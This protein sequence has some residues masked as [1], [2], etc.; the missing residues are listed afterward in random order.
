MLLPF[1]AIS[2]KEQKNT[3][4]L[5]KE[6]KEADSYYFKAL[7]VNTNTPFGEKQEQ[8]YNQLALNKFKLL[9][10]DIIDAGYF[11]DSLRFR[12]YLKAGELAHYFDS[13]P[14][15]LQYYS[16]AIL[17]KANLPGMADSLIFKPYIFSGHIY[18]YRNQLD[19][20]T[21]YFKKAE[22]IQVHYAKK[23]RES[24]RLYNDLGVLYFQGGNYRLAAN[25]FRK[26]SDMLEKSNPFYDD[27][28]VNY[29]INYAIALFKLESYNKAES[30]LIELLPFQKH[31]N[32]I[33]NNLG[34]IAE[35]K[36]ISTK[37]IKFYRKVK[38]GNGLDAGLENDKASSWL[39][40]KQF[41]SAGK[42]LEA[43]EAI[44]QKYNKQNTNIDHGLTYKISG[45]LDIQYNKYLTALNFYQQ[46]L[47]QFYPSFRENSIHINP[48]Q[49]SGAFSYIHVFNTLIAKA[50]ACHL[51]YESTG[52]IAWANDELSCYQSSFDLIDYIKRVYESD[53]A[54]LF[55]GKMK[56][57]IHNKPINLAIDLYIKTKNKSFLEKAFVLDQKNKASVLVFHDQQNQVINPSGA[58]RRREQLL[59]EQI[60]RLNLSA[61]AL[62]ND[63]AIKS[64]SRNIGELEI[65][66][67]KVQEEIGKTYSSLIQVNPKL[68]V[69]QKMLDERSLLLSYN[70]S[71]TMLTIFRITTTDI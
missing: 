25:Y 66:L 57:L 9:E 3:N 48:Q 52:N 5:L 2:Q 65:Q 49:F 22:D 28:W 7:K 70:I 67:G 31:L 59:K 64:A 17:L 44:S 16:H 37:A 54:R 19:S 46:A 41:D 26:A 58:L 53:E 63:S 36:G 38:Y 27:F 12:L 51:L 4:V 14:S 40:L 71:D 50:N 1:I 11:Y 13:L 8:L 33:N 47:H 24:E 23:L 68:A 10:K 6:F 34:L 62:N 18:F 61:A 39:S 21:Y 35:K 20:A 15:A 60:T 56:V 55:L 42:A 32:E 30:I 45:D 43:S 29:N 69:L